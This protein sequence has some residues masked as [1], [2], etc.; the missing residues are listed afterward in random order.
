ME[1]KSNEKAKNYKFKSCALFL[2]EFS[3]LIISAIIIPIGILIPLSHENIE[4]ISFEGSLWNS[5]SDPII[6]T[7]ISDIHI[8]SFKEIREYKTLFQTAKQLKA[9]FHLITG[10]IVDNYKKNHFPKV[11][12]QNQ[13][14]WKYYQ[15]LI[16][17]ELYNETILDIAGNHDMF[18]VITP[19]NKDFGY[20][21]VSKTFT[22]NNTKSLN[23]FLIKT[24]NIEGMN[25]ILLNP[26]NFPKVHPPYGYFTHPSKKFLNL[27][28]KEI[29]NVGP[30]NILIHYPIDFF[31]WKKN[32][33][34]KNLRK[35]MKN[36][37][38]QYIFSGHSHP[39]KFQIKHHEYG[40]LEFIASSAKESKDFG[41]V[42]IDNG[43]LVYNRVKFNKNEFEN[44]FMTY[45]VPIN[46]ISK[47]DNFNEKNTEIRVISYK[48]EIEDNLYITGDFNGKLE[49][50]REIK[51][52]IK[53][54]SRPLNISSE[55]EYEITFKAP[56]YEIKR[57]FYFGKKV[58][59]KGER[60][61]LIKTFVLPTIISTIF[62]LFCLLIINFP[63]K[64]FDF[65]F[66]DDWIINDLN[67][68]CYYY[69]IC[70]L[71][72]PFIL[73]YRICTNSPIYFRIIL[74]F[75][76]IYP[77]ILPFHFFEA[78]KGYVGYSFFCF[79]LIKDKI[80]YE[81]WAI[82][83]NAFYFWFILSPI[84]ITVS[85]FKFKQSCFYKF[86]FIL[87]YLFFAGICIINFRFAGESVKLL[88]LFFHPCFV[89]IPI[90]LNIFMYII[91]CK[92]HKTYQANENIKNNENNN[93]INNT[94][95]DIPIK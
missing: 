28:E 92:Y 49:Y 35:I 52:G 38:I 58:E 51:N 68:K 78:I 34:G 54:Y 77:L 79:Y 20:L 88:L 19:H 86:H 13:K 9:N 6:F 75:F 31:F 73:N 81:E 37:N 82:F 41:L 10:D 2:S 45:P 33:N 26:F 64:I 43:R 60:I 22:R 91:L 21:D 4:Y 53:L 17:N 93:N 63:L 1:I 7:H 3:Y 44:Y 16:E 59:I 42:T 71:L 32:K 67:E 57:K 65:S 15:E 14:D 95:E 55:G 46:Q 39:K 29:N 48:N 69:F 12:K 70:V 24:V 11:G 27:L 74:F 47:I 40:G 25:F 50:K 66:I 56:G 83:F 62:I 89:I 23:D 36:K 94:N 85:G 76:L 30:C 8:T 80:I 5:S 61:D 90:I 84:S 72:C 18:G 87:L